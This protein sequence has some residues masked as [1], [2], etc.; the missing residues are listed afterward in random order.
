MISVVIADDHV[1][2]RQGLLRL[3]EMEEDIAVVGE[4]GNGNAAIE[5]ILAIRPDV[6][7]L[8][9]VMPP[10]GGI[11][12]AEEIAERGLD[13][14]VV[15]LTT[16]KSPALV[17]SVFNAGVSAY[18][19]KDGAFDD[20]AQAIRTAAV[21]G[22]FITASLALDLPDPG[23]AVHDGP[24]TSREREILKMIARG[25]T[26]REISASLFI[27]PKTVETHR[28]NI[29]CKLCLS[30]VA[31]LVCYAVES[32]LIRERPERPGALFPPRR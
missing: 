19:L 17:R 4:C 27:S 5:M 29:M 1:P 25:Q 12:V 10:V 20:V 32:G 15:V 14:R 7:V 28:K 24:L 13:T 21:G 30:S 31:E 16:Y 6:A 26:G 9:V 22:T 8:D 11:E 2:F 18:A 3:M 23:F